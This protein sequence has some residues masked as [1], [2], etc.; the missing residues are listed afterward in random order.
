M[1]ELKFQLSTFALVAI[2]VFGGYWAFTSLDR[3]IS[4]SKEDVVDVT[5]EPA[6]VEETEGEPVVEEENPEVP[7]EVEPEPVSLSQED[8]QTLGELEDLIVDDIFMREGSRGTRVGTVQKFLNLYFEEQSSVDNQY[9]PGTLRRVREFQE[10]E[11][12]EADGLAGPQTYEKMIEI[13][14][15]G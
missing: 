12:L 15:Q 6:P 13:M 8:L 1:N 14:E 2:L 3:G 4:Y 10:A 7:Q 5:E 11:G 9:G